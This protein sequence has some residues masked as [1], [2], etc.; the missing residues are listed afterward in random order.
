MTTTDRRDN[1]RR[2][3]DLFRAMSATERGHFENVCDE[4]NTNTGERRA[5]ARREAECLI[6]RLSPIA[7]AHDPAADI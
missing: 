1:A 7:H 5:A 2:L 6:D 4:V 3:V